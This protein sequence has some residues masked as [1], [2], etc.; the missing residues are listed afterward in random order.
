SESGGNS[1]RQVFGSET[2]YFTHGGYRF[3]GTNSGPNM[4][5]GP[6]QIPRENLVWLDSVLKLNDDLPLIYVNHYPQDSSLNNWYEAIDR[7][8]KHNVQLFLCGHGHVN[9]AYDF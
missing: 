6:G 2:F 7:I 4:R 9:K 1:F 5:M 8:K 3:A